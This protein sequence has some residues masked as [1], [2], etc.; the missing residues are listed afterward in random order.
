MHMN[1]YIFKDKIGCGSHGTT[2]LLKV[3]GEKQYVVCKSIPKKHTK[4]AKREIN[5]LK[6]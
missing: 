1:R 2:Y 3:K 4:H 6:I 5:V